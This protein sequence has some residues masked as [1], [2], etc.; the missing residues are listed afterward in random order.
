ML[1]SEIKFGLILHWFKGH[2]HLGGKEESKTTEECKL[3]LGLVH[4]AR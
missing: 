2:D 4:T 1:D 3:A